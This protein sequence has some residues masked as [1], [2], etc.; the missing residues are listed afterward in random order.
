MF[1]SAQTVKI[2]DPG[3]ES[4]IRTRINRPKGTILK[5]DLRNLTVLIEVRKDIKDLT[6]LE[7][8]TNL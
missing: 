7:N 5:Y 6:G 8:L 2:T 4:A 3:L 1:H